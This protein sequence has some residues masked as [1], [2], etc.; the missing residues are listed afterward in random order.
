[1]AEPGQDTLAH[2]ASVLIAENLANPPE[3][4]SPSSE[5]LDGELEVENREAANSGSSEQG[6]A[7]AEGDEGEVPRHEG[8]G[9]GL[10]RADSSAGAG[11]SKKFGERHLSILNEFY[12][13]NPNP[14][15]K[16]LRKI[17]AAAGL[18]HLQ[19]KAWFQYQRKKHR[20]NKL[21]NHSES[22]YKEIK[23]LVEELRRTK[24]RVAVLATANASLLSAAAGKM[25][26]GV[27][28]GDG[29]GEDASP[30]SEQT[31][32]Q[33]QGN[34]Q[35]NPL[36]EALLPGHHQAHAQA[37]AAAASNPPV[38]APATGLDLN[39]VDVSGQIAKNA[40]EHLKRTSAAVTR[41][42]R[43]EARNRVASEAVQVR[44]RERSEG[45]EANRILPTPQTFQIADEVSNSLSLSSRSSQHTE[46]ALKVRDLLQSSEDPFEYVSTLIRGVERV[47][48]D[49]EK[50]ELE[51]QRELAPLLDA[52]VQV[53][54]A[55]KDTQLGLRCQ[56]AETLPALP[57]P[58]DQVSTRPAARC[59]SQ[60]CLWSA[61]YAGLAE[62]SLCLMGETSLYAL[63][64]QAYDLVN[65][66]VQTHQ[67]QQLGFDKI[68]LLHKLREELKEG[69]RDLVQSFEHRLSFPFAAMQ[70]HG[71]IRASL[72]QKL[73]E[74][75]GLLTDTMAEATAV[76]KSGLQKVKENLP[77]LLCAEVFLAMEKVKQILRTG[78]RFYELSAGS[79]TAAP[80]GLA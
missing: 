69:E 48:G 23:V 55:V 4:A 25:E 20:K 10:A 27:G 42:L 79:G 72:E 41:A 32:G 24:E 21:E 52:F 6:T 56:I 61:T 37:Q 53:E 49:N 75:P 22:L 18:T 67:G 80:P 31:T 9:P 68:I 13:E 46:A 59:E 5:E 36:A 29:G 71:K 78:D 51:K 26:A 12:K 7:S 73:A 57:P 38:A 45:N 74:S 1:M 19:C 16:Y 62:R 17:A 65:L 11:G 33:A 77:P 40:G 34:R 15:A 66:R 44:D 63:L 8:H 54:A 39:N 50:G 70:H 60:L 28:S 43:G 35:Q 14:K 3:R 2:L 47:M 30:D 76:Y 58:A 64:V